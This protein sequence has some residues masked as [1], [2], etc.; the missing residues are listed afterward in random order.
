MREFI[1]SSL[2][3]NHRRLLEPSRDLDDRCLPRENK[4]FRYNNLLFLDLFPSI[5]HWN[6]SPNSQRHL[7]ALSKRHTLT[8]LGKTL[9]PRILK[10]A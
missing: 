6:F 4:P 10:T 7:Y 1:V 3:H 2:H 5:H 8:R 9:S